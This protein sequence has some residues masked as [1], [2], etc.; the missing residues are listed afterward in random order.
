M[1]Y[2]PM[3]FVIAGTVGVPL[4]WGGAYWLKRTQPSLIV[5]VILGAVLLA[6][7]LVLAYQLVHGPGI[8]THPIQLGLAA[9]LFGLG[10][11][12]VFAPL[13]VALGHAA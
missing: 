2:N 9:G 7:G 10:I 13:R 12:Q 1:Q 11:N 4:I 3:M 5:R 8:A 6:S